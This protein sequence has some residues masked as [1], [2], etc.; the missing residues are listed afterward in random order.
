MTAC[1]QEKIQLRDLD[2]RSTGS[3]RKK[4]EMQNVQTSNTCRLFHTHQFTQ[5][6][7]KS[8]KRFVFGSCLF[9]G[10][11]YV[12]LKSQANFAL[13]S[14]YSTLLHEVFA[15]RNF[16]TKGLHCKIVTTKSNTMVRVSSM[17]LILI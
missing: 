11:E 13:N 5:V 10:L 15:R 12:T 14:V 6:T 2:G 4:T 1:S 8:F 17:V 7:D 9:L 3:P 16:K